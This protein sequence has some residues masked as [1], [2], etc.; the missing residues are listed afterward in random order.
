MSRPKGSKNKPKEPVAELPAGQVNEAAQVEDQAPTAK[1]AYL[2]RAAL[3]KEVSDTNKARYAEEVAEAEA[4]PVDSDIDTGSDNVSEN[5]EAVSEEQT[6]AEVEAQP[7]AQTEAS[8]QAVVPEPPKKRKFIIDGVERELTDEEITVLVQKS[9]TVDSRLAE[10]TRILKDAQRQAATPR[11]AQPYAAI[12]QDGGQATQPSD[13]SQSD[14]ARG[15][16]IVQRITK[17]LLFGNEDQVQ[18]A[19]SMLLGGG[20]Q[21]ATQSVNPGQIQGFVSETIAFENAKASLE[22]PVDQGGYADIWGDPM[23][24]ALFIRRDNEL[25]DSED[26]RG[27]AER[28]KA[29]AE[30]I[31]NWKKEFI[32]KHIPK[33]GLEDRDT[34]KRQAGV[35]RGGGGKIPTAPLES[36]PKTHDDVITGMRAARNLN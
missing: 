24:K 2:A 20:R 9:G 34:L 1:P 31:R 23:L 7:D 8:A 21:M 26:T 12:P 15:Q 10:A 11:G 25:L 28:Y 6:S 14:A 33:T 27:Y 18:E 29:I 4:T 13:T 32:G 35:V 30:E 19:V 16:E 3:L 5:Q 36:K 22:K 17:S